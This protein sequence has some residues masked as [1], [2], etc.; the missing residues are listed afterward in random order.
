MYSRLEGCR[1]TRY[2]VSFFLLFLTFSQYTCSIG[3]QDAF[4]GVRTHL[5]EEGLLSLK[6]SSKGMTYSNI[7]YQKTSF[8]GCLETTEAPSGSSPNWVT[9]AICVCSVLVIVIIVIIVIVIVK[10]KGKS[11]KQ[12]PKQDPEAPKEAPK[13]AT[14]EAPKESN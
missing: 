12:L 10:V 2:W 5:H 1:E 4:E 7:E 3:D 9:I 8:E 11:K 13:E 6:Y 14:E